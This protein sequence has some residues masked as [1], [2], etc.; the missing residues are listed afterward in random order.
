[1]L[2]L[3]DDYFEDLGQIFEIII[4][5]DEG[6]ASF[7]PVINT[8]RCLSCSSKQRT[9]DCLGNGRYCYM[10]P[11]LKDGTIAIDSGR[12][13]LQLS[14]RMACLYENVAEPQL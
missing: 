13:L 9:Q 14:L 10:K 1:M 12:D 3:V 8:Y 11:V 4:G 5:F 7:E 2:D 6:Y